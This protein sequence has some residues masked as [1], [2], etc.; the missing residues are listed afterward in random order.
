MFNNGIIYLW[1]IKA[2]DLRR[3]LNKSRLA[4]IFL[5]SVYAFI[6]NSLFRSIFLY[7]LHLFRIFFNLILINNRII[8]LLFILMSRPL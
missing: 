1:S 8:N 2:A 3:L 7:K 4:H 6:S 5:G